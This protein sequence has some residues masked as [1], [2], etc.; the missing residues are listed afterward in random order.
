MQVQGKQL[1][2]VQADAIFSSQWANFISVK[3]QSEGNVSFVTVNSGALSSAQRWALADTLVAAMDHVQELVVIAA[4]HLPFATDGELNVFHW[5][6]NSGTPEFTTDLRP[7]DPK[8]DIKDTWLAALLHFI[9]I[10]K[11]PS[12][13]LLL[14]K[15]YKP[16]RDLSGTYDAVDALAKGL[17]VF[18]KGEV[19]VDA[20]EMQRQLP[21]LLTK[22]KVV[23][24][25][26]EHLTL[27]YH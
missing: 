8:W 4:L 18:T 5:S 23:N 20:D 2:D 24:E 19:S 10:E 25:S 21:R 13:H 12:T 1:E 14:A 26:D 7:A 3:N 17:Q 11:A 16:G 15:G 6:L 22:E 27:L 9:K